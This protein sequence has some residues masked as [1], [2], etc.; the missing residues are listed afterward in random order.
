MF[1]KIQGNIE[2]V[3]EKYQLSLVSSVIIMVDIEALC[4]IQGFKLQHDYSHS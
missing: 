3:D 2:V 1:E 4:F